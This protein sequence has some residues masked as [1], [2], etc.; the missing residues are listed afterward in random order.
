MK[1]SDLELIRES[2]VKNVKFRLKISE[3]EKEFGKLKY[4]LEWLKPKYAYGFS[5]DYKWLL[6][7]E[8][9]ENEG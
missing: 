7:W 2:L 1:V 4:F 5:S 3:I 8:R 6:I 9:K